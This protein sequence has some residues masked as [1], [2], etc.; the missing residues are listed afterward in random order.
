MFLDKTEIASYY[1]G[2]VMNRTVPPQI[3]WIIVSAII[4]A[5]VL[6]IAYSISLSSETEQQ[7]VTL[8]QSPTPQPAKPK[9]QEILKV[10]SPEDGAIITEDTVKVTGTTRVG[11]TVIIL[12]TSDYMVQADKN[13]AFE[14]VVDLIEGENK[15]TI[16]AIDDAGQETTVEK[17]VFYTKENL[18]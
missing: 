16:T 18:E 10:V 9:I 17:V 5:S 13:G 11:A 14:I 15:L 6:L 2:H 4:V 12:A 7:T 3:F 8:S 1:S